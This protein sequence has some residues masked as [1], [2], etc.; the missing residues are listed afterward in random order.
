MIC[1]RRDRNYKQGKMNKNYILASIL[2]VAFA[3]L[4][5]A[6]ASAQSFLGRFWQ[7][8]KSGIF[9]MGEYDDTLPFYIGITAE[10]AHSQY[11]IVKNEN[12]NSTDVELS[13]V[14]TGGTDKFVAINSIKGGEIGIGIPIRIRINEFASVS[15]AINWMPYRG[16][17]YNSSGSG[18]PV[19]AHLEYNYQ[20]STNPTRF[21]QRE[22]TVGSNT[23]RGNFKTLEIPLHLK[24]YSDKKFMSTRD[25]HPYRLYLLGG[26]KFIR[27]LG[28]NKFN[29]ENENFELFG[30]IP[31]NFKPEYFALETGLG[32]DR[33]FKYF[34]ASLE[35]RYYQNIDKNILDQ[36]RYGEIKSY[37]RNDA[38]VPK[39]N[40][41]NP[42]MEAI[43]RLGIRGWR[44]S[45]ILE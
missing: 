1:R 6:E 3:F 32:F 24:I 27:N 15:T 40:Y 37:F 7:K 42:Y 38:P 26:G 41:T 25:D 20:N 4:N 31:L 34:K 22:E 5:I 45:I 14:S 35:L 2:L 8:H 23:E 28:A 33:Y 10:Y 19:G 30:E 43:D 39:P 36:K 18:K 44:L 16:D 13:T 29:N 12:W 21:F 11:Y 9:L 17:S